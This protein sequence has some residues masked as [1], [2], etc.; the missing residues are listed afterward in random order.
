MEKDE[1]ER[2]KLRDPFTII[3]QYL[4]KFDV[5]ISTI[6]AINEEVEHEIEDAVAF[7]QNSPEPDVEKFL[8]DTEQ[9][10]I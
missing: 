5:D 8:A 1:L 2:W 6:D 10:D 7:A 4:K 3:M 9:F